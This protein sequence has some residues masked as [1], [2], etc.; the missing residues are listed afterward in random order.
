MLP[1]LGLAYVRIEVVATRTV[2][3]KFGA[4]VATSGLEMEI[5]GSNGA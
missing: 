1:Q 2:G 5:V 4:W 3:L